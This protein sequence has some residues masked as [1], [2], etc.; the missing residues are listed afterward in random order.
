MATKKVCLGCG[1]T[2][3]DKQCRDEQKSCCPERK[4]VHPEYRKGYDAGYQS[5]L[6]NHA[7]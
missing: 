4:L 6:L 2:R 7:S 5:A 3:T 1:S